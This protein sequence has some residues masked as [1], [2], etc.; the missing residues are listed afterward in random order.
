LFLSLDGGNDWQPTSLGGPPIASIAISPGFASDRTA[1]AGSPTNGLFKSLDGGMNWFPVYLP[2]GALKIGKVAVSP[3]YQTD[4]TVLAGVID[5]GIYKSINGGF[6]WILMPKS[7]TLRSLDIVFSPNWATDRTFFIGTAQSGLF[8]SINGGAS[9]QAIPSPDSFVIALAISPNFAQDRTLFAA[10]YKGVYK[11]TD[12]GSTWTYTAE[13]AR[14]EESRNITSS[15]QQPPTITYQGAWTLNHPTVDASSNAYMITRETGDTAT[16]VFVG[17]GVRWLGRTGPQQGSASIQLDGVLQGIV[18]L[19][20]PADLYQQTIWEQH[21]IP[22]GAHTLTLTAT[23]D[24]GLAVTLDAFDV[25]RDN[26]SFTAPSNRIA[27]T[28]PEH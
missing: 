13:P 22:C 28:P 26:C 27:E 16:F 21:G 19:N 7:Q 11:S 3:T 6:T 2:G 14:V 10:C 8:K 5:G 20:A 12:A 17:S 9:L 15:N 1:F 23:L 4:Y 25:W 18:S 24:Q